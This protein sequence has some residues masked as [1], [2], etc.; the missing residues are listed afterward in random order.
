MAR[1]SGSS[2]FLADASTADGTVVSFCVICSL[3]ELQG[4]VGVVGTIGR[5]FSVGEGL[6]SAIRSGELRLKI[7]ML[8]LDGRAPPSKKFLVQAQGLEVEEVR[9]FN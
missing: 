2:A 9:C 6:A 1:G 4:W 3:L 5:I 8:I 7:G